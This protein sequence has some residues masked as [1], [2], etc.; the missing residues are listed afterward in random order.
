MTDKF[1]FTEK[2]FLDMKEVLEIVQQKDLGHLGLL[3]M[4]FDGEDLKISIRYYNPK[5]LN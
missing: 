2:S 5:K 3:K 1:I 4:E